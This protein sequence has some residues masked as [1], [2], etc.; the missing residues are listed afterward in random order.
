M[1]PCRILAVVGIVAACCDTELAQGAAARILVVPFE[2]TQGRPHLVWLGEASAVVLADELTARGLPAFTRTERVRAFEQ[3]HLPV[4]AALS[5]ATIIRVGQLLGASEVIWGAYSVHGEELTVEARGV[6]LETGRLQP[7]VA[8]RGGLTDLFGVFDRLARRL[9]SGMVRSGAAPRHPPLGAFENYV[10]GLLAATAATQ[11]TFFE[12]AIRDHPTFDRARIAL[13]DVR[14]EQGD[15]AAALAAV[16][17]VPPDSPFAERA[18]FRA[19]VS[20]LEQRRLDEAETAFTQLLV[21]GLLKTTSP[22]PPRFA[23][24]LN[25]LGIV[26]LRRSPK[27]QAGAAAYYFTRAADA[28]PADPDYRFNLGYAYAVERNFK[29]AIYWLRESVRRHVADADAHHVL[30]IAL[31]ATGS[32][33]EAA[34]ERDLARLLSARYEALDP[35]TADPVSAPGDLERLRLELLGPGISQPDQSIASTAQQ[36]Q[37]ELA[38]FH[39]D[40]GRDLFDREQD[41][42]AMVE[43]RRSVY[44]S[45][46]EAAAHLLIGRIHLRGGRT[47]DAIDALKISVWSEDTSAAR[48]ALAEAYLST[49]NTEAARAELQRALALDPESADAQHLLGTIK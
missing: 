33:V 34:R 23:P 27:A 30:A 44:L 13:W 9:S 20:L 8:E 22:A 25:N 29:A 5:R 37:R 11:A 21:P 24:I 46:Y 28:E 41:R 48:V 26:A 19:G 36:E 31:Q 42:E 43:L 39:L 47:E 35:R 12:T 49:S 6:K 2:N 40:R 3:L 1:V 16:Q 17:P 15:H 10:K 14:Y 18:R 7:L 4:T 45:P 32:S 38:A